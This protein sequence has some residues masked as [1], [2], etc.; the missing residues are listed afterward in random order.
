MF[1]Y[2]LYNLTFYSALGKKQIK[3]NQRTNERINLTITSFT[4]IPKFSIRN[5]RLPQQQLNIIKK[6]LSYYGKLCLFFYV[7][8]FF[9]C[10][11]FMLFFFLVKHYL[12][13]KH[14]YITQAVLQPRLR[15]NAT[16]RMR[17]LL[18]LA[19]A[20]VFVDKRAQLSPA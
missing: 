20:A 11:V 5:F 10:F 9:L 17:D 12:Y 7:F 2:L 3:S 13:N 1:Q 16:S 14:L 4:K 8:I 15:Y 18:I 19:E 6:E